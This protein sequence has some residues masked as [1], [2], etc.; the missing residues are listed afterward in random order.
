[1]RPYARIALFLAL[2]LIPA[3]ASATNLLLSAG[4]VL[5]DVDNVEVGDYVVSFTKLGDPFVWK[6]DRQNF[7]KVAETVPEGYVDIQ[8][9]DLEKRFGKVISP[10]PVPPVI[11]LPGPGELPADQPKTA[12]ASA[13]PGE[14]SETSLQDNQKL[15]GSWVLLGNLGYA[16]QA[17]KDVNGMIES[18]NQY[19]SDHGL[20]TGFLISGGFA[21]SLGFATWVT[22]FLQVGGELGF[23]EAKSSSG[24]YAIGEDDNFS[25]QEAGA[26]LKLGGMVAENI[27][28]M[29]GFGVYSIGLSG[30]SIKLYFQGLGYSNLTL[31][32]TG[33]TTGYKF[34]AA[35][36]YRLGPTFAL[37]VEAGYR[38]AVVTDIKVNGGPYHDAGI[39]NPDGS[40][41]KADYSGL[42]VQSGLRLYF[43]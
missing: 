3:F 17:M 37:G 21:G 6:I 10:A 2:Y 40:K 14:Q 38:I 8:P 1:M 25:G 31:D 30:A 18:N 16:V 42:Y 29:G 13:Q 11:P 39:I 35:A 22:D 24:S 5:R 15:G 9:A 36:D 19:F 12:E 43:R 26:F 4:Y 23:L 33:Q 41:M 32:L 34:M 20:Q 7:E 28:V 27:A